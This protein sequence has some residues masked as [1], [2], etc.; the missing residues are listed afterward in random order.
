MTSEQP[1]ISRVCK[2]S[3]GVTDAFD[4]PFEY[5]SKDHVKVFVNRLPASFTWLHDRRVKLEAV[6]ERGAFIEIERATPRDKQ[7]TQF[8]DGRIL[9]QSDLNAS[10][11]QTLFLAQEANDVSDVARTAARSAETIATRSEG[12]S[13]LAEAASGE[14]RDTASRAE[15]IAGEAQDTAGTAVTEAASAARVAL[16][17]QGVS[18]AASNMASLAEEASRRAETVSARAREI[19]EA[20]AA[21][22][23]DAES[24]AQGAVSDAGAAVSLA[25]SASLNAD[26]AL[27]GVTQAKLAAE[28]AASVAKT[29]SDAS[30]DAATKVGRVL[31]AAEKIAGGDLA[32][33]SRGSS[34]LADLTD[35][36]AARVN[37]GLG[38]VDNTADEDKPLSKAAREALDGKAA[39][40]HRHAWEEIDGAP[41]VSWEGLTGKPETFPPA[42]HS[43]TWESLTEKPDAFPPASHTHTW[44]ALQKKPA[45]FPPDEH[46]HPWSAVTEKPAATPTTRGIVRL[47]TAD[48]VKAGTDAEKAVT[49]A[50][51]AQAF[52]APV[53]SVIMHAGQE[54]PPLYLK[55]NGA[56]LSR[57]AYHEL[58]TVIGTTFGSGDG[59][60]TFAVPDLRGEFL[61]GW[62]DGRGVDSGRAF[63]S[64]Q[65]DDFES[66]SHVSIGRSFNQG[67]F[68]AT[69]G[70]Y[71]IWPNGNVDPNHHRTSSEGGGETRPRNIALLPCIRFR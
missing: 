68:F 36:T 4:I 8:K 12:R 7:L 21:R 5:L 51:L 27:K 15:Q 58:F 18:N 69:T 71:G 47:A 44:G 10:A 19:A 54:P 33:L 11:L 60:T 64:A 66:H 70:G 24:A 37:L 63:G 53:G 56:L 43:H 3:D 35:K 17:A 42:S 28:T 49:P 48:E 62:D 55:C 50:A 9:I 6:P 57:A 29:A 25:N 67:A 32:D 13:L 20:S 1:H 41:V 46:T 14:A 34:N 61:R 65:S 2:I 22:S 39:K 30:T 59:S 26:A 40:T 52:P 16:A 38:A 45:T 31:E 23:S